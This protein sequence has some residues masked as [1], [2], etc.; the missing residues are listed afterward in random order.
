MW[1]KHKDFAKIITSQRDLTSVSPMHT[2]CNFLNR[3]R[4]PL[5]RLHRDQFSDLKEQQI[6]ARNNLEILQYNYHRNPTDIATAHQEKEAREKYI[7][8]LSSS[9]DLIKQQSKMEW[10]G[11]GDDCT[12]FF[13]A[14]AK[15]RKISSYI[16]TI[17]DQEGRSVEGFDQVGLT[18]F[19]HYKNLLGEQPATR[20]PIDMDVIA[21]GR[22]LNSEQQINMCRPFSCSDIKKAFYSIPNH[23]SP[24]PD[25]YSSGFFKSTWDHIGPLVC[26]AIQNFFH[27][28]TL[29]KE[30]CATKLILIPKVQNPQTTNEFRPISCCNVIYKCIT[31]LIGQ[32]IKEILPEIIHPSQGAFVKGREL[33][34]NVLICQ[35]LARGYKRSHIS[36]RCMLKI[37]IQKAFDS[38]HWDFL[39]DMLTALRLPQIF[40]NWI[41]VCVK[42]VSF[43]VHIN[44]R[45]MGV[46]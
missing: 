19:Q 13:Y 29:P 20:T 31:K 25:G 32:R 38:V 15:R 4:Y 11:Y 44:G 5:K 43:E 39:S 6:K 8:I 27:H 26:S 21:L 22:V 16:Y 33:L 34:Y 24:G 36:P 10:I 18:M 35:D 2:L 37:D 28:A 17:T 9:L 46:F 3:I 30:I 23:K 1:S 40:I 42:S 14:K 45:I 41:M 7:S 12:R